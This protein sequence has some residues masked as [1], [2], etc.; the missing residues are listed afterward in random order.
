MPFS[1]EGRENSNTP[2]STSEDFAVRNVPFVWF[3][4]LVIMATFLIVSTALAF[5]DDLDLLNDILQRNA[6]LAL[7]KAKQSENVCGNDK[8][9]V[10]QTCW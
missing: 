8:W 5:P 1:Y 4:F 3:L 7:I 9:V 10:H 2:Y 6:R